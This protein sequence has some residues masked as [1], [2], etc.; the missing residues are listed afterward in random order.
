MSDS[1]LAID[2]TKLLP[3]I[4]VRRMSQQ[5]GFLL[6][7]Y[8]MPATELTFERTTCSGAE[9]KSE[10]IVRRLARCDSDVCCWRETQ[11]DSSV[12]QIYDRSNQTLRTR[13]ITDHEALPESE[14]DA[15]IQ[16]FQHI[17]ILP[18]LLPIPLGFQWHVATD[19]GDFMDFT[20]E[21]ETKIGDMPVLFVQRKGRFF[22]E[23]TGIVERE[24][25]TA[26]ALERSVVLED[27]VSDVVDGVET[28]IVTKLV[29]S[30]MLKQRFS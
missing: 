21:S 10:T 14:R 19:E 24:G 18:P 22:V 3:L 25:I 13:E 2:P 11:G 7:H 23:G 8:W 15:R 6:R 12:L 26:F 17:P 4:G 29:Q 30:R 1:P 16:A 5:F 27:R 20:L 28:Y 9:K